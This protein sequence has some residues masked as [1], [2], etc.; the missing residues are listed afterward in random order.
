VAHSRCPFG[1]RS[2]VSVRILERDKGNM[3]LRFE[4]V[5]GMAD[6][7]APVWHLLLHSTFGAGQVQALPTLE[8]PSV[9]YKID[10][11]LLKTLDERE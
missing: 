4:G 3:T 1:Q 10:N 11:L 2:S 5:S 9:H 8:Y 6:E 7:H